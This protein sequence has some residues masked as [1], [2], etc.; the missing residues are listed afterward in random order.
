[1]IKK[2]TLG[3]I[4]RIILKLV[5]FENEKTGGKDVISLN[6]LQRKVVASLEAHDR[7]LV[8]KARQMGISTICLIYLTVYALV[9]PESRIA[10]VCYDDK[11]SKELLARV[12]DILSQLKHVLRINNEKKIILANGTTIEAQTA[13]VSFGANKENKSLRSQTYNFILLSEFAYYNNPETLY[14]TV[15]PALSKA[16]GTVL[17][18]ESTATARNQVFKNLYEEDNDLKK[19]FLSFMDNPIYVADPQSISDDEAKECQEKYFITSRKHAAFWLR[20][21][22]NTYLTDVS[23][24][25]REYPV[26]PSHSFTVASGRWVLTDPL[27]LKECDPQTLTMVFPQD[28]A[29][30]K[31]SEPLQK[32]I[33]IFDLSHLAYRPSPDTLPTNCLLAIDTAAGKGRDSSCIVAMTEHEKIIGTFYSNECEF[34]ELAKVAEVFY[35]IF[36]PQ[37][38]IIEQNG[39]FGESIIQT[40]RK[41]ETV[42][43]G[44]IYPFQ[45]TEAT[46]ETALLN[47]KRAVELNGLCAGIELLKE[48][49]GL[50]KDQKTV[51]G[52]KDM[53]IA[54][55]QAL[56]HIAMIKQEPIKKEKDPS[57]VLDIG[58]WLNKK[59]DRYY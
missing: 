17:I 24:C 57:K 16:A 46:K 33:K 25:L 48:I 58:L 53:V 26:I 23:R 39:G 18:I 43:Y 4:E 52:K 44:L 12:K 22:R 1:M 5:K 10:I 11:K 56:M 34:D 27:V 19:L 29:L 47:T 40:L 6:D 21:L 32:A 2:P 7:L 13:G 49:Q 3:S 9:N 8:L 14:G 59:S 41:S 38:I 50:Y 28:H 42:P 37:R 20:E 51:K 35:A 45:Q 15:K 36:K 54:T 30:H 31:L 55:G